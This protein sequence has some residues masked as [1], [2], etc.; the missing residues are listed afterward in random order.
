MEA[1]D[2]YNMGT[3]CIMYAVST[4][5]ENNDHV[6]ITCVTTLYVVGVYLCDE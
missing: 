4:D 5:G 6:M 1:V 2:G 3:T